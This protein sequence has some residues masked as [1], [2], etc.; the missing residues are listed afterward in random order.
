MN[1]STVE[2]YFGI[3]SLIQGN[4]QYSVWDNTQSTK[5]GW[6]SNAKPSPNVCQ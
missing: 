4:M 1:S 6:K 5:L 2:K 3:I